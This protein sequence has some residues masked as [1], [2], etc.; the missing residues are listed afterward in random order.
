MTTT[1]LS[2]EDQVVLL[3]LCLGDNRLNN[4][5]ATV[6]RLV[7]PSLLCPLGLEN[8]TAEHILQTCPSYS[9]VRKTHCP[10]ETFLQTSMSNMSDIDV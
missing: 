6:M 7:R 10:V 2:R 8:Q 4:H 3:R 5:M 9:M 1:I